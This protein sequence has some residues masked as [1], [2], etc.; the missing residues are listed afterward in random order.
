MKLIL[1][2]EIIE[3]YI[4]HIAV[5]MS[6]VFSEKSFRYDLGSIEYGGVGVLELSSKG[7]FRKYPVIFRLVLYSHGKVV[8]YYNTDS[9][10]KNLFEKEF[11]R[12][13][14]NLGVSIEKFTFGN[15]NINLEKSIL[16]AKYK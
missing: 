3:G 7:K 16:T 9:P 4:K 5:F 15:G 11:I 6:K 1:S 12:L 14:D 10:Y 13:E 2:K 8:C